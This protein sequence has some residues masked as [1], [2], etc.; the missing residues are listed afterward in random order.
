M[1][2]KKLRAIEKKSVKKWT[3]K[4]NGKLMHQMLVKE[5]EDN[6][7]DYLI[8]QL[9]LQVRE[10]KKAQDKSDDKIA[11]LESNYMG[12]LEMVEELSED[13]VQASIKFREVILEKEAPF[14][15]QEEKD[16]IILP[17]RKS[18]FD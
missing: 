10:L 6:L 2:T 8:A 1:L 9:S 14:M 13:L 7:K 16:K 4:E 5:S 3:H 12:A 15:S 18:I 11:E 17:H